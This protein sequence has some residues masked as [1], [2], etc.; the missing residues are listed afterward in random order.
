M[1]P[2]EDHLKR[3]ADLEKVLTAV[4]TIAARGGDYET[5]LGLLEILLPDV[6][7]E[8]ITLER[9]RDIE[10]DLMKSKESLTAQKAGCDKREAAIASRE[11][12]T[13]QR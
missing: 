3:I 1:S 6:V 13:A 11:A 5:V 10:R 2:L 12:K 9:A 4:Q 7:S 8:K